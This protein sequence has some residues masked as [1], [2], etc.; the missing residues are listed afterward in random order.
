MIP[1]TFNLSP[2]GNLADC[3]DMI[4]TMKEMPKPPPYIG[5]VIYYYVP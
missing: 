5:L 1:L 2:A 4:V 3:D